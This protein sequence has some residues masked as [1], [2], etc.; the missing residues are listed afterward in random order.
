[1]GLIS[2]ALTLA[3]CS[4][5]RAELD[6]GDQRDLEALYGRL[7]TTEAVEVVPGR[8]WQAENDSGLW[9][10]PGM[11]ELICSV[12]HTAD[13]PLIIRI[14]PDA[15][16]SRLHFEARWDDELVWQEPRQAGE[17]GMRIE[18]P[19][20]SLTPGVHRLFL[21]RVLR[22]DAVQDRSE[23]FN[24]FRSIGFGLGQVQ[25]QLRIERASHYRYLA[26]LL[27]HATTGVGTQRF[28]GAVVTG[29][30]LIT[31]RLTLPV[32]AR[33]R[34]TVENASEVPARFEIRVGGHST[35]VEVPPGG[36]QPMAADL[37]ADNNQI[38]LE[39]EGAADGAFLWGAPHLERS[40]QA[41]LTP[42]VLI[43]L[44]TTRRDALSP[45]GGPA[46]AS[47]SIARFAAAATVFDNAHATAPWTLPTHASM[48]T[49]LYPIRHTAGVQRDRLPLPHT[50]VA[51]LLRRRGYY[52]AGFAGGDL[53]HSRWGLG[54]GFCQYTDPDGFETRGDRLTD[55]V[56]EL[57]EE[58]SEA[59]LF[60]FANYFDPHAL[61]NAP[62]RFEQLFGV[63][64][65]REP[66]RQV[67]H[68]QR[69]IN[70]DA[71][72]WAEIIKGNAEHSDRTAAY[73]RAAYL[74]EVAFM[75]HHIGRLLDDL[76]RRGL[77]D[78]ALIILVADHG[79]FLGEH[80]F[81]SHSCRLD[82]EL[83][84]VPL[85]I[86]W[87]GQREARRVSELVSQVDL[88]DTILAVLNESVPP[89]DGLVIDPEHLQPLEQRSLVRMEEHASIIHPL[90]DNMKIAN[91]LFGL[92]QLDWRELVWP[93]GNSCARR[94]PVGW[95]EAPCSHG[96]RDSFDRISEY[97]ATPLADVTEPDAGL[98]QEDE[99]RLRA[100]GYLQ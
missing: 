75:D 93:S 73:V 20:G 23:R 79:E 88:F 19:A 68:W 52:T 1:M 10:F 49:G 89:R 41:Q 56:L 86:K 69:M 34:L 53:C 27:A 37:A 71:A 100:L 72:A 2:L 3:A 36:H 16:T 14:L 82:P 78:P 80:G 15:V 59:P 64:E 60:L 74:A 29:S 21:R 51:E 92:Q 43:T 13:L 31:Q 44:D 97:A 61:F 25:R 11:A 83:T 45:Y 4:Q 58:H 66:L 42:V 85:I 57:L 67:K 9:S 77:F 22:L 62:D 24:R 8:R 54:Q 91:H 6:L 63:A 7:V 76:A 33:L 55:A 12:R 32:S 17:Q 65:L 50:T 87:P 47:P 84:E 98:T 26:D 99:T 40:D 5:Q 94:T 35:A 39:V 96:W 18:I 38:V 70:G 81:Y 30:G 48:L 46:E 28:G 95:T 90:F